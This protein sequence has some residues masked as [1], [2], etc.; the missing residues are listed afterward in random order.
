MEVVVTDNPAERRFDAHVDG[1]LAGFADY[2]LHD[3][4]ITFPHVQVDAAFEGQGVGS[5]LAGAS[6]DNAR[7]RNLAVIPACPFM[8]HFISEHHEYLDLVPAAQR[9]RFGLN[10]PTEEE[11]P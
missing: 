6:L 8:T 9:A 5:H 10:H 4:Q 3:G 1:T 11:R 2:H 7:E